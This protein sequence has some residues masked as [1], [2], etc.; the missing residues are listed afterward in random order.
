MSL[1]LCSFG[2]SKCKSFIENTV[3]ELSVGPKLVTSFSQ[4]TVKV[5]CHI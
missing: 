1:K 2:I 3:V 4:H 5:P